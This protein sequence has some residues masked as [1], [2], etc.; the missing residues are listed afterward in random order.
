VVPLPQILTPELE[1][2]ARVQAEHD[3]DEI[4][5]HATSENRARQGLGFLCGLPG[6]AAC[7]PSISGPT[8][9][10]DNDKKV[11]LRPKMSIDWQYG[12]LTAG[13][14]TYCVPPSVD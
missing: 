12:I 11:G 6:N 1:R 4:G 7:P 13:S 3:D 10:D 14:S 8:Q 5:V 2:L 9:P